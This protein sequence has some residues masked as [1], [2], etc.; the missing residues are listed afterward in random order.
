MLTGV[1]DSPKDVNSW[2]SFDQVGTTAV[3]VAE[4]GKEHGWWE[5]ET[6]LNV[7]GAN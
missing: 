1:E 5:S 6:R 4:D 2:E 3:D 7:R